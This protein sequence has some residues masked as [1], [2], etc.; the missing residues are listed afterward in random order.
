MP[1]VS[2]FVGVIDG[3]EKSNGWTFDPQASPHRLAFFVAGN[4]V[5][6]GR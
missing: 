4:R 6:P 1:S 5:V 2:G 3:A